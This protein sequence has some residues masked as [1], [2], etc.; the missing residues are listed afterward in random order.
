MASERVETQANTY[1]I[2]CVRSTSIL[3]Y[4]IGNLACVCL[5][6]TAG[7]LL[8]PLRGS[9]SCD[10]LMAFLQELMHDMHC[11]KSISYLRVLIAERDEQ[12]TADLRLLELC[13]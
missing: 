4:S 13:P 3:H 6:Y 10:D 11:D 5:W 7:S 9:N 1:L 2:I 8:L 12:P